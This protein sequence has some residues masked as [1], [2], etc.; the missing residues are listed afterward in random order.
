MPGSPDAFR[1]PRL[2]EMAADRLRARI[3]DG[4]LGDGDRL[5]PLDRLVA[6][7][8]VSKPTIREALRILDTEGLITVRRG[9]TGGAVVHLPQTGTTAYSIGLV[10]ESRSVT[11][12][13]VGQALERLEADCAA[14]C[15]RRP[16]RLDSVVPAL[17]ACNVDAHEHIDQ[18]LPYTRAMARFHEQVI[19]QC[20][21]ATLA[22]V[23]GAVE[24]LWLAHVR[25]WAERLH[26]SGRFPATR[27]RLAGIEAHEA[28]TE[29]IAAGD[30]DAAADLALHHFDPRQFHGDGTDP[31]TPVSAASLR[32][33][34]PLQN[35]PDPA[36]TAGRPAR[37]PHTTR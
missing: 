26:G 34:S 32:Q 13:D 21:N 8:G 27:Y 33:G 17:R 30:A 14:L 15:A 23:A 11:L 18:P 36:E 12:H 7:F 19:E 2:A 4:E 29:L 24:S 6:E 20:G 10:L 9:A 25:S 3:L 16:D 28:L 37:P 35:N 1:A 22:A 5:P 31:D